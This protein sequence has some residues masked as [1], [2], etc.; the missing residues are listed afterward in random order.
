M[1]NIEQTFEEEFR[2]L[3]LKKY[4]IQVKYK[5]HLDDFLENPIGQEIIKT[6]ESLKT[7]TVELMISTDDIDQ[8]KGCQIG[9]KLINRILDKLEFIRSKAKLA[10]AEINKL[11]GEK[12]GR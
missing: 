6:V 9:I 10:E 7:K 4:T 3:D 8:L 5:K 1:P 2:K 11:E 12:N